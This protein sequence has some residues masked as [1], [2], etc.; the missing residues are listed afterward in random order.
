[1]HLIQPI[2][3]ITKKLRDIEL[4]YAMPP[5]DHLVIRRARQLITDLWELHCD[6]EANIKA[7]SAEL[8]RKAGLEILK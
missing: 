7:E 2:V 5:S 8:F 3:P 6:P 1:M 4:K